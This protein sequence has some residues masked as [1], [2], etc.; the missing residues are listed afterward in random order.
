[1]GAIIP[2]QSANITDPEKSISFRWTYI[3][4]PAAFLLISII[5]GVCFYW[6]LPQEAAYH[7][8][9]GVPDKWMSPGALIAWLLVPQFIFFLFA[10]V[11]IVVA[12]IMSTNLRLADSPPTRKLLALMGNMVALPQIILFFAMLDIF[13]YNAYRTHLMLLWIFALIVMVLG[14][15]ILGTVFIK[16]LRQY[17]GL[18]DKN[19]QE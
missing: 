17:R 2:A 9:G 4:L 12:T 8:E 6:S 19:L 16:A 3:L 7:F 13:L 14:A 1:M 15:I 18:P 11:I 10:F 5:M